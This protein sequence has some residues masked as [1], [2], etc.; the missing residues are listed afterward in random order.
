[1]NS[2]F[3]DA[4]KPARTLIAAAIACAVFLFPA[5]D[6]FVS[7]RAELPTGVTVL[8]SGSATRGR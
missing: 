8:D 1:M 2:K 4:Q 3:I 7:V 5:E 6:A